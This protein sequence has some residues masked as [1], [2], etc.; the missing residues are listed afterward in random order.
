MTREPLRRQRC[1]HESIAFGRTVIGITGTLGAAVAGEARRCGYDVIGL[2]RDAQSSQGS[3]S[4]PVVQCNLEDAECWRIA[5]PQIVDELSHVGPLKLVVYTAG[6]L[7]P[8]AA[9]STQGAARMW[10]V[11]VLAPYMLVREMYDLFP[12]GG[13]RFCPRCRPRVRAHP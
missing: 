4:S 5:R 7:V 1:F 11:N 10:G 2:S 13:G 8:D 6:V 9:F 12:A 3:D